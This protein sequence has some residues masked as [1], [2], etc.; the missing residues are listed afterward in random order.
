MKHLFSYTQNFTKLIILNLVDSQFSFFL[1]FT[2]V[3]SRDDRKP[4]L[5]NFTI[6]ESDRGTKRRGNIEEKEK[7]EKKAD[8]RRCF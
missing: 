1:F 2:L 6:I 5:I 3:Y 4:Y 8:E 7:G